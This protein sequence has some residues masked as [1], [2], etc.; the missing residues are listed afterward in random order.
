[1]GAQARWKFFTKLS[2]LLLKLFRSVQYRSISLA[3]SLTVNFFFCISF[4]LSISF[5]VCHF[6]HLFGP[7]M[8]L[9]FCT[10]AMVR[11]GKPCKEKTIDGVKF[12]A[13]D[14]WTILTKKTKDELAP[15]NLVFTVKSPEEGVSCK[16]GNSV[17]ENAVIKCFCG[18]W[19]Y[20]FPAADEQADV[21]SK[22]FKK[23]TS[24]SEIC[25]VSMALVAAAMAAAVMLL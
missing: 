12:N 4:C 18:N 5:S 16:T 25:Q 21:T 20:F 11:A 2:N 10:V 22:S 7:M 3:F 15:D 13:T 23:I 17:I 9:F 24:H 6:L 1:M 14:S 8:R 19:Y